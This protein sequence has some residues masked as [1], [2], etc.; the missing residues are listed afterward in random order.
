MSY[1]SFG[2]LAAVG[3]PYAF[4]VTGFSPPSPNRRLLPESRAMALHCSCT[5]SATAPPT[6]DAR[7]RSFTHRIMIRSRVSSFGLSITRLSR[8]AVSIVFQPCFFAIL[9]TV[10]FLQFRAFVN[11]AQPCIRADRRKRRRLN[12]NVRPSFSKLSGSRMSGYLVALESWFYAQGM[13]FLTGFNARQTNSTARMGSYSGRSCWLSVLR[14]PAHP[15]AA[16]KCHT[17]SAL[18]AACLAAVSATSRGAK[19]PF[20]IGLLAEHARRPSTKTARLADSLETSKGASVQH[21]CSSN[22]GQVAVCSTPSPSRPSLTVRSTRTQPRAMPSAF[23]WPL[24]VPSA[25][26]GSG[27]G[28]LGS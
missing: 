16:L 3:L 22:H 4:G 21:H 18:W 25:L 26:K 2:S 27:A 28:Y 20:A 14:Q 7:S 1:P 24:V 6:P 11:R 10:Q 19:V 15:S 5:V 9:S 17:P 13:G 8:G 12:L 23:S